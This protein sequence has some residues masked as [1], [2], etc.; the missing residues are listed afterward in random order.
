MGKASILA[1][2]AV[3]QLGVGKR[4][5][6]RQRR[7]SDLNDFT[8]EKAVI[9]NKVSLLWPWLSTQ[10]QSSLAVNSISYSL[11]ALPWSVDMF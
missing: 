6:E 9:T 2:C 10:I 4:T 1:L 3:C 8:L 7:E 5:Q 11:V